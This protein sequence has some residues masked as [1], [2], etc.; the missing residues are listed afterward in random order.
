MEQSLKFKKKKI[1]FCDI[2]KNLASFSQKLET[3]VEFTLKKKNYPKKFPNLFLV[4]IK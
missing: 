4:K 3:S 1:Q 2:I